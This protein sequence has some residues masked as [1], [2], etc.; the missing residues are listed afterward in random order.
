MHLGDVDVWCLLQVAQ[1]IF[2]PR[3][4]NELEKDSPGLDGYDH[5]RDNLG[6]MGAICRL[7]AD[8]RACVLLR[9]RRRNVDELIYIVVGVRP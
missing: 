1:Q 3:L 7:V 5:A 4:S 2:G 8:V 6:L 9:P